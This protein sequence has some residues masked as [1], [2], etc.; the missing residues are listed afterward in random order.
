MGERITAA[1]K[2]TDTKIPKN[3]PRLRQSEI[4]TSYVALCERVIHLQ[5]TIGNRAVQKL[6]NSG[7]VRAKLTLGHPN[8]VS[9]QHADRVPDQVMRM[10]DKTPISAQGRSSTKKTVELINGRPVGAWP[11]A[12]RAVEKR[13][14]GSSL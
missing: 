7:Y 5:R 6:L 8:D 14:F 11:K 2:T 3:P 10:P 9:G 13:S 1:V 4:A 12:P